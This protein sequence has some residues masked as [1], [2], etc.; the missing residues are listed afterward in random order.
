[1]PLNSQQRV[2]PT[3][4]YPT[5][6]TPKIGR[7]IFHIG[8]AIT[9]INGFWGLQMMAVSKDFIGSQYG[10]HFQYLTIQGLFGSIAAMLLSGICDY[11]PGVQGIKTVKR[12]FLLFALPIE[13]VISSIYWS[14][15][16]LS[17]E[18]MLPPNPALQNTQEPSASDNA[19]PLFRIPLTMD[20]SMHLVPAVVLL[21]D[22]FVLE[23]KFKPPVSNYGSLLLAGAFGTAYSVWVEHCASINGSFPYPFLTIMTFPQ[24][25]MMYSG[26]VVM[27]W[28]VFR[29]L[30]AL[31]K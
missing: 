6:A 25:L 27:A 16:L 1:M 13:L 21:L 23:K 22:F 14:I 29:G 20:L 8:S 5:D 7:I 31:H 10:G 15:I 19:D 17:P 11:L 9:M 28:L 30:N 24:R 3:N 4:Q 2:A 12:I 26:S 18:L